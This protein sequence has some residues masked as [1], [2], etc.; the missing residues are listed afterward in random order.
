MKKNKKLLSFFLSSLFLNTIFFANAEVKKTVPKP[1]PT[2]KVTV[3]PTAKKIV[4]KKP[5]PK[6]VPKPTEKPVIKTEDSDSNSDI[7]IDEIK[8][9]MQ[10]LNKKL[11]S[12]S[13]KTV[14]PK[15]EAVKKDLSVKPTPTPVKTIEPKKEEVKK[16]PSLKP[17]PIPVKSSEPKKDPLIKPS[18]SPVKEIEPKDDSKKEPEK[19]ISDSKIDTVPLDDLDLLIYSYIENSYANL[20]LFRVINT[21][22]CSK[23]TE[24]CNSDELITKTAETTLDEIKKKFPSNSENFTLDKIK[25]LL[26]K[27]LSIKDRVGDKNLTK[28]YE[29]NKT[30][31]DFNEDLFKNKKDLMAKKYQ[32]LLEAKIKN[33]LLQD[34]ANMSTLRGYIGKILFVSERDGNPEIYSMNADSSEEKR[35]TNNNAYE[36]MPI[37]S[38]DGK[39]IAFVSDRDGNPEIYVMNSD[40]TEQKRLTTATSYDYSPTWSPDGTKLAFISNREI[41]STTNSNGVSKISYKIYTMNVD[42]TEQKKISESSVDDEAPKWSPDGGRILFVSKR[43]GNNEVYVMNI[44][45]TNTVKLT[46]SKYSIMPN[47]SPDGKKIVYR[48]NEN[49]NPEVYIMNSDGTSKI[50]ITNNLVAGESPFWSP[51]GSKIVFVSKRDNVL[52]NENILTNEI[53]IMNIDGKNINRV[54]NNFF[55]DYSPSWGK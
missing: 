13:K 25:F 11:D 22:L 51:D 14:Q 43:E 48:G 44:D 46:N 7:E 17:T 45:G 47:W 16:D 3:K 2:P 4:D 12:I 33:K 10:K 6:P 55:D 39:K 42:G 30:I 36:L 50:K 54:T 19:I 5:I 35:L 38:P 27:S 37:F 34:Q 18:E 32:E 29:M 49:G 1:T 26:L 40:G 31:Q 28:L 52:S 41:I 8:Q 15:K 9:E 53:Y 24:F 20:E 21:S 23:G